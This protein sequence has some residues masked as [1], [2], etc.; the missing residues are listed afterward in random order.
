MFH[1]QRGKWFPDEQDGLVEQVG[2]LWAEL[3][4]LHD[5]DGAVSHVLPGESLP[6]QGHVV[7]HAAC[8]QT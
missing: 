3:V 6:P 8:R 1:L 7:V 2:G 5:D 4:S